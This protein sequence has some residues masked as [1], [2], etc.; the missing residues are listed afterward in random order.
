MNG[1]IGADKSNIA[2][3]LVKIGENLMQSMDINGI[4]KSYMDIFRKF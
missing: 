3:Q 4:F 1:Y 2:V